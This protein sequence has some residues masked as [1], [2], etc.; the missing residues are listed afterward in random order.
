MIPSCVSGTAPISLNRGECRR[1]IRTIIG[2]PARVHFEGHPLPLTVE[3]RDI[4]RDGCFFWGAN[5][6][7]DA[8]LG[9]GFILPGARVCI[10]IGKVVRTDGR[11]FGVQILR[12]N[13]AF[14]EFVTRSSAQVLAGR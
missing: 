14:R 12:A 11:G 1:H 10:A 4:S 2:L 9:F 6:P 3:L 5:A 8:K 7:G 13:H